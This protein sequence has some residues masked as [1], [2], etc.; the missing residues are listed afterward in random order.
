MPQPRILV[1]RNIPRPALERLGEVFE[2]ELHASDTAIPRDRL[3][4]AVQD[5]DALL[6]LLTDAINAELLDAAPRLKCVSNLAVGYNNIDLDHATRKGIV[7]CNTPGVL[8]QSTADLA[9]ALIL[10]CARRVVESDR[11]VREGRFKGWG[12][13]LMLGVDVFGKTL[14]IIGIGRIG[15]A[16]ARRAEGFGMRVLWFD[17]LVDPQTVASEYERTDLRHLCA[18]SDFITIHAPLTPAT[19]HL[20]SGEEF[21]LMRP[22]TILI[23][24][25]RGPLVDEAALIQALRNRQIAAAG[26]DV[27]ERE[28]EIPAGL[29]ELDNAVLLPHIGSA[30]VETRTKMALMAA[31]NAI[32]VISGK[33]PPARVY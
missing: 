18:N 20:I 29:L 33:T 6:C 3:L 2:L 10:A 19:E 28:P 4:D 22:Q 17:P 32:A 27:Y 7:V 25:A 8:T 13:M 30:S 14:G 15:S 31:E 24:S 5:K 1:T 21:A 12:P 16:V 23:N 9:W 26:L 11:Y